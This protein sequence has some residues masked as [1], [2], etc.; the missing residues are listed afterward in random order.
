MATC[1][2]CGAEILCGGVR[3]PDRRYCRRTCQQ[4]AEEAERHIEEAARAY[5]IGLFHLRQNPGNP[6]LRQAALEAGRVYAARRR[7][8]E[9]GNV[10]PYDETAIANDREAATATAAI[11]N[12]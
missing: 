11:L 9:W 3:T 8:R 6:E 1:A 4:K 2:Y 12:N 7:H 10:T 5:E